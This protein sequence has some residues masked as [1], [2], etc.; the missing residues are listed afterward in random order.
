M[1]STLP[2]SLSPSN[3]VNLA[4]AG[5][6][7]LA[8]LLGIPAE[9]VSEVYRQVGQRRLEAAHSRLLEELRAGQITLID[10]GAQDDFIAIWHRYFRAAQEGA[11][12]TNL[13]LMARIIAGMA[14]RRSLVADQFLH[15]ADI[16]AGLRRDELILVA[17]LHRHRKECDR[18]LA[19]GQKG[20]IGDLAI[21]RAEDPGYNEGPSPYKLTKDELIP[22]V[23][24]SEG[25]FN[26]VC[27]ALTRTG[28]VTAASSFGPL[29]FLTSPLM[30]RLESVASV[31]AAIAAEGEGLH[32]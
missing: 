27:N 14:G 9:T 5:A 29:V 15:Y 20:H 23:F 7:D 16:L 32:P 4:M 1:T 17:T 24:E 19:E 6:K 22:K 30:D 18:K 26:A 31:E 28:L 8:S 21:G 25:H 3:A 10:A 12:R 2:K 11:A 13:R